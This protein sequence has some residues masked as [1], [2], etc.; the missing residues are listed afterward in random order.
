MKN[1]V[2]DRERGVYLFEEDGQAYS[3]VSVTEAL[4]ILWPNRP[5]SEEALARGRYVHRACALLDGGVDNLGLASGLDWSTVDPEL[6]HPI[7]E[8]ERFKEMAGFVPKY[9]EI[10]VRSHR[11]RFAGTPDVIGGFTK[12]KLKLGQGQLAIVD[13]KITALKSPD[14]GVQLAA[15]QR[16][17]HETLGTPGMVG[18]VSVHLPMEGPARMTQW[19]D[20]AD[21]STFLSALH[22]EHWQRRHRLERW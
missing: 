7:E 20:Q 4:K 14:E 15:Y 5:T 17:V 13:R 8:W 3:Y 12:I 18:R 16:A 21:L 22:L 1:L 6:R 9:V 10:P 11:Y 19:T 2:R